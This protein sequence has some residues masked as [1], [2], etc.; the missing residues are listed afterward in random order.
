MAHYKK[1][2]ENIARAIVDIR[3]HTKWMGRE[4]VLEFVRDEA[5]QDA[6][7]ARNMWVRAISTPT[8][9]TT[10]WLGDRQL[11]DLF[12]DYRA[13]RGKDFRVKRFMDRVMAAGPIPIARYR[14]RFM[15]GPG[16]VLRRVSA[17]LTAHPLAHP[18]PR[19]LAPDWPGPCSLPPRRASHAPPSY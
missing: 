18:D 8:Q 10:Y 6:Q 15:M 3:V 2:L 5:L 12:E 13:F 16:S 9:I 1:Q 14:E 17:V 11:R 7:F 19:S 4:E